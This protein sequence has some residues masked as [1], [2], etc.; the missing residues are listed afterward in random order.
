MSKKT[1]SI[2]GWL[3]LVLSILIPVF[4]HL[5]YCGIYRWDESRNAMNALEMSEGGNPLVRTFFENPDHWETKPPLLI[6]IQVIFIKLLGISELSLRLPS[7]L[8]GLSLC[9]LILLFFK[10]QLQNL[11]AGIFSVL[12]LFT[13][14][15]YV[16]PHVLRSGEHDALLIFWL[17]ASLLFY[18][19]FIDG[20]GKGMKGKPGKERYL[21]WAG[22][23]I[24]AAVMT[25]SITGLFFLP[26]ML[27]STLLA[28]RLPALI[29]SKWLYISIGSFAIV[30]G[31]Y[32]L[33]R[34]YFDP[35]Y[36]YWV[37][38]NELFK[39]YFNTS[40]E[41]SYNQPSKLYYLRLMRDLHL[42]IWIWLLPLIAL[43]LLSPGDEK[44]GRFTKYIAVNAL[45]FIFIISMGTANDWYDAPAMPLIA[46][47]LGVSFARLYDIA[48]ARLS[49]LQSIPAFL[50]VCLV[51]FAYPY[52]DTIKRQV[53]KPQPSYTDMAYGNAL[54][55]IRNEL[56]FQL[57]EVS[58]ITECNNTH[59]DFYIKLYNEYKGYNLSNQPTCSDDQ[60]AEI[61]ALI[62][63][64]PYLVCTEHY[65]NLIDDSWKYETLLSH[66]DCKLIQLVELK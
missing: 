42:H 35:E 61:R 9:G 53:Y 51:V 13:T 33:G 19:V 8:A 37:N 18:F 48:K 5:D 36:L 17:M 38:E 54:R 23:S 57:Q 66:G 52:F 62:P 4:L 3:L 28:Q 50:L 31:A 22:L 6:W 59:T 29:R 14:T 65:K 64:R 44:T 49:V 63:V 47:L 27:L 60:A 10:K 24:T 12:I 58:I 40:D 25:K 34:T 41:Y 56:D 30:V 43:P 7:A 55:T 2:I 21:F 32:Y 39:R 15:G 11:K 46:I 16:R 45:L 26:G 20:S 1:W